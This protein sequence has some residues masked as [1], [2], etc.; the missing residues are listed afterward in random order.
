M[1][2]TEKVAQKQT[3]TDAKAKTMSNLAQQL[4]VR[5]DGVT[6]VAESNQT[7]I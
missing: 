6:Q 1:T 7:A 4:N 2:E 3:T 5:Q